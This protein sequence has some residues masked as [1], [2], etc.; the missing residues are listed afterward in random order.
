MRGKL[1]SSFASKRS[2]VRIPSVPSPSSSI[3]RL[4]VFPLSRTELQSVFTAIGYSMPIDGTCL[5]A[6]IFL[7]PFSRSGCP[8]ADFKKYNRKEGVRYRAS[9]QALRALR[10]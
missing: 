4:L 1:T 9:K 8:F 7:E 10:G 5:Q 6:L 3:P 2:G